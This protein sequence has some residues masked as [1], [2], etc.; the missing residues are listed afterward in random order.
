M[1]KLNLA[2]LLT[3]TKI[4]KKIITNLLTLIL[5]ISLLALTA[6][7][8]PDNTPKPDTTEAN[9]PADLKMS[10]SEN[11]GMSQD[12]KTVF[13]SKDQSYI[14]ESK[15]VND[16]YRT[17]IT[18]FTVTNEELSK[19][20]KTI[21]ENNIE[22]IKTYHQERVYDR[23]GTGLNIT[24]NT[25]NYYKSNSGGEFLE[26]SSIKPFYNIVQ[27]IQNL[28]DQKA[29][30]KT[31]TIVMTF[32]KPKELPLRSAILIDGM[33]LSDY[34]DYEFPNLIMLSPGDHLLKV[35]LE[36]FQKEFTFNPKNT[37]KIDITF[38]GKEIIIQ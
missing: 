28:A 34:W 31:E 27:A 36:K 8:E 23:G 25:I 22:D 30:E 11:G 21:E 38:D 1:N 26:E 9:Y 16:D 37:K 13:I 2:Q 5:A 18:P 3:I 6:C 19:L 32:T 24:F 15:M 12:G 20:Y 29:K 17:V 14:D 35:D 33:K 4:M 7:S 10:S